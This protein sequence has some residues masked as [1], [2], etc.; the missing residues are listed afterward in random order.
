MEVSGKSG[1]V[2]AC[3]NFV[4]GPD[5]RPLQ[6]RSWHLPVE[7]LKGGNPHSGIDKHV[8]DFL[9]PNHDDICVI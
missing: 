4:T 8:V 2:G 6:R 5:F 9:R 7:P 3:G 1:F